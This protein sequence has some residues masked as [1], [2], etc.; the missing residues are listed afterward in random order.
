MLAFL[1][2]QSVSS[3]MLYLAAPLAFCAVFTFGWA[4]DM[5][6][7][8]AGFGLIGNSLIGTVGAVFGTRYWLSVV[9]RGA[10]GGAEPVAVLTCAGAA[11]TLLLLAAAVLKKA[12][13]RA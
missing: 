9:G 12:V 5:V 2:L 10:F 4:A 6:M 11:A 8:E 7:R 1:G 13:I 3:E